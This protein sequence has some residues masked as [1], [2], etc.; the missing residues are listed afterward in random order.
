MSTSDT[1]TKR[2]MLRMINA[3]ED[4]IEEYDKVT[5]A[6]VRMQK[7]CNTILEFS[8][9]YQYQ[10]LKQMFFRKQQYVQHDETLF[11]RDIVKGLEKELKTL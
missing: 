7:Y 9:V 11:L 4:F 2:S 8:G 10:E 3:M 5:V 1:E 6:W